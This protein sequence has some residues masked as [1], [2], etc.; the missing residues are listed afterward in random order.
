MKKDFK[1]SAMGTDVEELLR[2]VVDS[3]RGP[4]KGPLKGSMVRNLRWA[5]HH[6]FK[7]IGY[8]FEVRR[9]GELKIGLWRKTLNSAAQKKH[10]RR[11]VLIPGFGDSPLS[12]LGVLS[13]L[14]P[15]LKKNYDEIVLLDFPGF[16]GFLAHER[17]FHSMDL[18]VGKLFEVLD[19]LKP[20]TLLGH[21]L[22]GWLAGRYAVDCGTGERPVMVT[23]EGQAARS[24]TYTG[25]RLLVLANPSGV[26]GDESLKKAWSERMAQVIDSGGF[27]L[28]RPHI[29]GKEPFWFKY[30]FPEF[31]KFSMH[32]DTL[33][34][35]KSVRDDHIIEEMAH[36]IR[37]RVWLL[38]GDSDT[39]TPTV[40][41]KGWLNRLSPETQAQAVL[42]KGIGHSPHVES[43]ALTALVL[44]QILTGEKPALFSFSIPQKLTDRWWAVQVS[45]RNLIK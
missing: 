9:S 32:E 14:Q 24:K 11:F 45:P 10:P 8:R 22:G 3:L 42:L 16:Q 40:F 36:R 26:F 6:L 29:F 20:D 39:L 43:P 37:A 13:L 28:L 31:C 38:W 27:H 2:S 15:V 35:M 17:P 41:F 25:P 33:N 34:F 4:L 1:K 18:L 12:W 30:L 19:S 5:A 21:S 44:S 7:A 23:A